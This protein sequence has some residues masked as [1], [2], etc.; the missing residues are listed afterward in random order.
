MAD[1]RIHRYIV[2]PADVE[3]LRARRATLIDAIR[4]AFPGLIETRLIRLEDGRFIDAWR[5]E[6][7]EHMQAALAAAPFPE[8][9]PAWSL[10]R[11]ATSTTARSSTSGECAWSSSAELPPIDDFGDGEVYTATSTR[12]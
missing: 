5:W 3:E 8:A 4:A 11:E 1:F 7:A 6:S 2:D 10:T 12:R 9:G